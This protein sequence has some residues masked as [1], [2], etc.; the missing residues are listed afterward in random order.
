MGFALL[1]SDWIAGSL[2]FRKKA[3]N[4]SVF[5]INESGPG[6]ANM[7]QVD[8]DNQNA[9]ITVAAMKTGLFVHTSTTGGG[10]L[11]SPDATALDAGFLDWEIGEER[12]MEY[13]NDGNQTV[14]LTGDTGVTRL[15]AQT[16]ATLQGRTIHWLKTAASTYILWGS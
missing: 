2:K 1:R 14:T 9:A 6:R 8:D 11:T 5:T 16:I 15:S 13:L 10:T 3:N 7:A 4:V 12:T